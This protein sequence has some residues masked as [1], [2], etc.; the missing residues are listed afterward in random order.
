MLTNQ[1]RVRLLPFKGFI[2]TARSKRHTPNSALFLAL[3]KP[4]L[5]NIW[6]G[7]K[8]SLFYSKLALFPMWIRKNHQNLLKPAFCR[9]AIDKPKLRDVVNLKGATRES[10]FKGLTRALCKMIV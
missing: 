2:N 6:L 3:T 9:Q 10:G 8:A 5:K 4:F 7:E 1:H